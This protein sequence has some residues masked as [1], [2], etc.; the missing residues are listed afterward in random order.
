LFWKL[1][2]EITAEKFIEVEKVFVLI[3]IVLE[4]SL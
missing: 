3:L 2:C 1:V 4:V